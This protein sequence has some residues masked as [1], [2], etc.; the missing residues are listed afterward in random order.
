VGALKRQEGA[1]QGM[2]SGDLAKI[3]IHRQLNVAPFAL[4]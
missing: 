2:K 1:Q 4:T 3:T